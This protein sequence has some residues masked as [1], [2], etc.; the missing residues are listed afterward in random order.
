MHYPGGKGQAG[1]YQRLI[2]L[3]PPHDFRIVS[4]LGGGNIHARLRPARAGIAIDRD[5]EVLRRFR[6]AHPDACR[7]MRLVCADAANILRDFDPAGCGRVFVYSDPPYELTGRRSGRPL[8]RFNYTE[9]DHRELLTLLKE[10]PGFV[11][12]SGIRSQLYDTQ[13]AAWRRHDFETMTRGGMRFE[14]V[15]YNYATP[16][17]PHDLRYAGKDYRERERIKRKTERWKARL[18][19]LSQIERAAIMSALHEIQED[20]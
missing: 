6:A 10:F 13:L 1:T 15:W 3:I 14:S 20:G 16:K 19:S 9:A 12:L 4:H 17:V 8:Y 5:P 7:N 18:Q 11:L 2:N